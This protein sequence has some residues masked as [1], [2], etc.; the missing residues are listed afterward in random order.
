MSGYTLM[1]SCGLVIFLQAAI[2]LRVTNDLETRPPIYRRLTCQRR[3]KNGPGT[4][5]KWGQLV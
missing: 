2:G 5:L 1:L 3:D 4:G